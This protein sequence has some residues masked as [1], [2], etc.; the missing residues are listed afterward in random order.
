MYFISRMNSSSK[1]PLQRQQIAELV[2]GEI[3]GL[4]GIMKKMLANKIGFFEAQQQNI[5]QN[6]PGVSS[7][8]STTHSVTFM[9]SFKEQV[10]ELQMELLD[11]PSNDTVRRVRALLTNAKSNFAKLDSSDIKTALDM[12]LEL[13]YYAVIHAPRTKKKGADSAATLKK[14]LAVSSRGKSGDVRRYVQDIIITGVHQLAG[15]F[16]HNA[17]Y[18]RNYEEMRDYFDLNER[19]EAVAKKINQLKAD[20]VGDRERM[21]D[22]AYDKEVAAAAAE[23]EKAEAEEMMTEALAYAADLRIENAKAEL[24]KTASEIFAQLGGSMTAHLAIVGF[25]ARE[26]KKST[27]AVFDKITKED[28]PEILQEMKEYAL[29]NGVSIESLRTLGQ[30]VTPSLIKDLASGQEAGPLAAQRMLT[31]NTRAI[32]TL[33]TPQQQAHVKTFEAFTVHMKK[34]FLEKK[35]PRL[36]WSNKYGAPLSRMN[37]DYLTKVF[38]I[39]GLFVES[40]TDKAEAV[41]A[42]ANYATRHAQRQREA[43]DAA[44]R[45][46]AAAAEGIPR[47]AGATAEDKA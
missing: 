17:D 36:H 41:N 31:F 19:G 9:N 43:I 22:N 27:L 20:I 15:Q 44:I 2:K 33:M 18:P 38:I 7:M 14:A 4:H 3:D 10:E 12:L 6:T 46:A 16:L 39:E 35:R 47:P 25:A 42:A 29:K 24:S 37:S 1:N 34:T 32:L 11:A 26:Y 28:Y 21:L 40:P 30:Q 8:P 13:A 23:A 5:K 45:A